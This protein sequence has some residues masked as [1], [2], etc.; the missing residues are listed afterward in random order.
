MTTST[1]IVKQ[2][3]RPR[4]HLGST[5]AT[6]NRQQFLRLQVPI[7][8]VKKLGATVAVSGETVALLE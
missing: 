1:Q 4:V 2:L 6:F 5:D 3:I 8:T 7:V